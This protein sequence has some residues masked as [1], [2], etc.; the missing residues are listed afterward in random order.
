M[1]RILPADVARCVGRVDYSSAREP[2]WHMDC[3]DCLR[4]TLP[5]VASVFVEWMIVPSLLDGQCPE[6][7]SA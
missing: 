1:T 4:R 2:D 3:R 7:L 5:E 6:R